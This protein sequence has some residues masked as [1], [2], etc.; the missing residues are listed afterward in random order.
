MAKNAARPEC[1]QCEKRFTPCRFNAHRQKFCSPE[2]RASRDRAR[3]RK[4]YN[5]RYRNDAEFQEAERQRCKAGLDQ[6][7]KQAREDNS[8]P[9]PVS[10]LDA[11]NLQ[12]LTVGMLSSNLEC[13]DLQEVLSVARSYE[14]RGQALAIGA[15]PTSPDSVDAT[16]RSFPRH[17][18]SRGKGVPRHSL[19]VAP[20]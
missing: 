8:K 2:C 20:P 19:A 6:R 16:G 12:L 13:M 18:L 11:V 4:Y 10:P 14:S 3:K 7:R 1:V 5:K 9:P 15:V 17:S